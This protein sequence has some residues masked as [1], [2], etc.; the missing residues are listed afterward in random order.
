LEEIP[1]IKES[2]L[3]QKSKMK[4]KWNYYVRYI[5]TYHYISITGF[6]FI[7]ASL[8]YSKGQEDNYLSKLT[9]TFEIIGTVICFVI[10]I[11]YELTH[12]LVFFHTFF[13]TL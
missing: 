5:L 3:L 10:T 6:L 13:I 8:V 12:N 11:L 4:L 2:K 1:A 9:P 7:I